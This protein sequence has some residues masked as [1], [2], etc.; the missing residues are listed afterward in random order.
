MTNRMSL[1]N[2]TSGRVQR[3]YCLALYGPEGIGKSTFAADAPNPIFLCSE[4]GTDQ[5]DVNRFPVPETWPDVVVALNNLRL[6]KHDR[7]TLVIDT[8]DWLEPLAYD[9][10]IRDSGNADIKSIE[11]FGWGKGYTAAVDKCWRPLLKQ[12]E[13]L[14]ATMNIILLAH[15]GVRTFNNP[16]G[17]NF[18]RYEMKLAK[19][20]C[21]LVKEWPDALL[22]AS[23]KVFSAKLDKG[24]L[25]K[26]KGVGTGA[27]V[28]RTEKRPAFDAKN[29]YG[30]PFELE[31]SWEAFDRAARGD[32][33]ETVI[34]RIMTA[35]GGED[36]AQKGCKKFAKNLSKLRQ[37][38]NHL[39]GLANGQQLHQSDGPD[40]G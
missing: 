6:E 2:T 12:L 4:S 16:E 35:F 11:D 17:E 5:L 14:R 38:E 25:A 31:L 1:S 23:D 36:I 29:R 30:L 26:S 7:K 10:V 27:R 20:L 32:T 34:A 18:D 24:P 13:G 21:G 19:Q 3:N 40:P 8:V 15:A 28:I 37:L 39:L 22:F 33:E 9:V